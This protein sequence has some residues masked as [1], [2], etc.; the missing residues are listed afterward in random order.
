MNLYHDTCVGTG[1]RIITGFDP[2][3]GLK[4][5]DVDYWESDAWSPLSYGIDYDPTRSFFEQVAELLFKVPLPNLAV[6]KSTMENSDFTNGTTDAKNCYLV[7]GMSRCE[8]CLFSLNLVDCKNVVDTVLA[9]QSELCFDCRSIIRCYDLKFSQD[10]NQCANSAFLSNCQSCNDCFMCVNLTNK[11]YC[12]RNKQLTKADY[13]QA[14][15]EIDLGSYSTVSRLKQEFELFAA[16]FPI[17]YYKGRNNEHSSGNYLNNTKHCINSYFIGHTEEVEHSIWVNRVKSSAFHCMYGEGAELIYNTVTTGDNAY[18]IKF[19]VECWKDV[20]NL[21]Y[22]IYTCHGA[23]NCFGCVG[24]RRGSYCVLNK[25]YSKDDYFRLVAAIKQQMRQTGEYGRFFP[26][27]MSLNAYNLS[28]GDLFL[29]LSKQEALTAGFLWS[30]Q[31]DNAAPIA[32][33]LVADSITELSDAVLEGELVCIT[34]GKRFRINKTEL[35]FYRRLQLPLPRVHPIERVRIN[36]AFLRIHPLR[37]ANC[38]TCAT[39]ITTTYDTAARQ[40]LCESCYQQSVI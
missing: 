7:F 9:Q 39:A 16:D 6:I 22:C 15:S 25:Q 23:S 17:K 38:H 21:E 37:A 35:E 26:Q 1:K 10:C 20:S 14:L 13:N 34:T 8:D 27:S 28:E 11:R 5:A 4:V 12:F 30:D 3:R 29:P 33:V 32:P 31:P 2:T 18:N 36:S 40:V 19:C 24:M